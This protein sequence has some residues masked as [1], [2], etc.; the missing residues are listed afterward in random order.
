MT[1]R[2]TVRAA[3]PTDPQETAAPTSEHC[4]SALTDNLRWRDRFMSCI[5][6]A[7]GR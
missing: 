3:E 6:K 4:A 7:G 5:E 2:G 1:V